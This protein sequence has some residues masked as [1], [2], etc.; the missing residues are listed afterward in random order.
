MNRINFYGL[1]LLLGCAF[2]SV[3][4]MAQLNDAR[5]T[6]ASTAVQ[7]LEE[8][9]IVEGYEDGTFKP[10]QS[11]NRAEFL[12]IVLQSADIGG[13]NCERLPYSDVSAEA[14][15]YDLVCD[16][17]SEGIV[18]G[19]PDGTFRPAENINLAEASKIVAKVNAL[20]TEVT[21]STEAWYQEFIRALNYNKVIADSLQSVDQKMSRGEM[22][23]MVWGLST[24]NEVN[25][26]QENSSLPQI[27]SCQ[28]LNTEIERFQKRQGGNQ[29]FM[30]GGMEVDFMMAE[31][32]MMEMES[33]ADNA[34]ATPA[35]SS[36]AS[37]ANEVQTAE[38]YS[39]T[40]VQE[41]GVDEA[42]IVKNDGQ[43]IYLIKGD[44]IRI[45]EAFPPENMKAVG[46]IKVDEKGFYPSEMYVDGDTLTVIGQ[47]SQFYAYDERMPVKPNGGIGDGAEPLPDFIEGDAVEIED[48][49]EQGSLIDG[50][51]EVALMMMPESR[52]YMP[53]NNKQMTTLV[54]YDISDKTQP[55]VVRT[56]SVEGNYQSSRKI[57][58]TVYLV[59]NKYND[60]YWG[61]PVP[62]MRNEDLPTMSDSADASVKMIAPCQDIYYYPN[63]ETANYLTVAAIDTVDT[64][65]DVGR[66]MMLGS[67]DNVYSSIENLYVTRTRYQDRFISTQDFDGWRNEPQ[68]HIYKFALDGN[69]IEFT[70]KGTVRGRVLN[71]FSMSEADGYFRIATQTDGK[72]GSMMT[73][74]DEGLVQTGQVGGIAPGENIKSVRFMGDKA[75]MI[76]FLTVDPLF[77][78]DLDPTDPEV[79]GELKIP[80]WSDYLHPYDDNH[81]IGIGREVKEDAGDDDRL[82]QDDLLGLKIAL[83][84]VSD[85]NNPL[86]LHKKVIGDNGT[87]SE[88]TSNHKAFLFDSQEN[89]MALP[90][91]VMQKREG[92]SEYQQDMV[93]QG[94]FIYDVSVEDGFELR[95]RASHYE[96]DYWTGDNQRNRWGNFEYNVQR[97]LFMGDYWYTVAQNVIAAHNWEDVTKVKQITLD[98]KACTE[99]YD[100]YSCTQN[101]QCKTIWRE[102]DECYTNDEDFSKVCEE[103]R[104]FSRC[105]KR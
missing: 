91:T 72:D 31:P 68:T 27:A 3:P 29:R 69:K 61:R 52:R 11:I 15:Y 89:V 57:G 50:T 71:Q 84:D 49:S 63:F 1:S 103:Q 32:A 75:Y 55:E 54:A 26:A 17:T 85:L 73:I 45:I 18:E 96:D 30:R 86:E 94:A 12:K 53:G 44:S 14:W 21:D 95:G 93:F 4:V 74:L 41:F 8:Q 102:W 35:L 77:V 79:L 65:A 105:E 2:L 64:N 37:G 87:T 66:I 16:A 36:R 92:G 13:N 47:S 60:W 81:L 59:S 82:T 10:E 20:E 101:T 67:G 38:R 80:G 9:G 6:T 100:E 5:G 40:N 19:Y 58:D 43:Y 39:E 56:V 28:A 42:D 104:E 7:F 51:A 98:Q 78:I 22:A 25:E 70:D 76:T 97:I 88:A 34:V 33:M 99:M 83:F 48:S 23:Q 24:G 62:F 46:S 90:I